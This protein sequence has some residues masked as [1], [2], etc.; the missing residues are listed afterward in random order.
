MTDNGIGFEEKYASEIFLPFRR[1]HGRSE[2]PGTGVGLA[3][4]QRIVQ[5]HGGEVDVRSRPGEGTTFSIVLPAS[6]PDS[7]AYPS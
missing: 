1:L 5:R 6:P 2:Y 3:I 4:V 7:P